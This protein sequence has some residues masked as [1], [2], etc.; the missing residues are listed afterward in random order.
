MQLDRV[1]ASIASFDLLYL[2]ELRRRGFV[3]P[4]VDASRASAG[5]SGGALL[6]PVPGFHRN[7]AVFDFKSL[8]PSLVRTFDLDPLA[9]ALADF[10]PAR[11]AAPE[12]AWTPVDA[13]AWSAFC[14]LAAQRLSPA[15]L[16][17]EVTGDA[18][19]VADVLVGAGVFAA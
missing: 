12:S 16:R 17:H 18:A 2:P 7:V 14:R 3:A 6:D 5:V 10:D 4:S 8:Y 11:D 19:T 1:G 9:H 15:E 13:W